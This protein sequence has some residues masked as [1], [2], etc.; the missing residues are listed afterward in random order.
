MGLMLGGLIFLTMAA[1]LFVS[2]NVALRN[3]TELLEDKSRLI[4]SAR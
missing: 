2:L 1:L 3:T 4:M